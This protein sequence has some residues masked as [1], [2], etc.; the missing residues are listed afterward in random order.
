MIQ[1]PA[2]TDGGA[3]MLRHLPNLITA[4]RIVLVV[5][6]CWLIGE[7]RYGSALVVA[8]LAGFSDAVDGFLAK[9]FGWQSRLGA[10]LD[11]I[12]DKLLLMAA[13][14]S[15]T[16]GGNLP[17]WFTTIVV[18]RDLAIVAGAFAYH[19]LIG[20][21]DAAPS[22]LSKL[23]TVAQIGCVLAVLVRLSGVLALP[24]SWLSGLIVLAAALTVASGTHYVVAWSMQAWRVASEKRR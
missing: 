17:A 15:L 14:I 24:R 2:R 11:P 10:V 13:C 7:E 1:T 22:W 9:H 6:L 8:A 5:P 12:A 23:T 20:R 18:A 19:R 21:F 4:L 3:P 16:L